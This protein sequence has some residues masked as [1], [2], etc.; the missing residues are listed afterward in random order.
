MKPIKNKKRIDPRYFLNE[1]D[2]LESRVRTAL[3]KEGGAAGLDALVK[4]TGA[5]EEEIK[6]A[7]S[8]WEGIG[9]HP[10]GDYILQGG[11]IKIAS[12]SKEPG[13]WANIKAKKDRIKAGSGEKKARPGDKDYPAT[14][15]IEE[16]ID[17]SIDT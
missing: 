5:T 10:D 16:D 8:G 1:K 15:D 6:S 14:L 12:E 11:D 2:D 13:L 3:S 4:H 7:L 17:E 9:I